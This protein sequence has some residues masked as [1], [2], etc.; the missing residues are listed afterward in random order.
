MEA[1]REFREDAY[2]RSVLGE[3]LAE[4]YI[5][6]KTKEYAEYRAQVTEWEAERYLHVL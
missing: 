3:E 6:A 2:I 4:K 1:A 5:R